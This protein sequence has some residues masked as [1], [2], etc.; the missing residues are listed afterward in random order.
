M[1]TKIMLGVDVGTTGAKAIAFDLGG[2]IV[3]MSYKEYGCSYPQ[4]GWAEQDADMLVET[5]FE[6]IKDV[7]SK[8]G[9]RSKNIC[10]L[11]FST[12]RNASIFLDKNGKALRMLTW[13]DSRSEH[14]VTRMRLLV[15]E[16][17]HYYTTGLP[18]SENWYLPKIVWMEKHEKELWDKTEKV[19]QLMEYLGKAYGADDYY[20]PEN[21]A[22]FTSCW[23]VGE[24]KW[25]E[26]YIDLFG[27]KEKARPKLMETSKPVG[28]ISPEIAR[29][30]GLPE[31]LLLPVAVGDTAAASLGAGIK[32]PGD[33]SVSMG[34]GGVTIAA[35]DKPVFHKDRAFML[36]HHIIRNRWQW[37]GLQ[38]ASAGVY[39]W[40]KDMLYAC[41]GAE[42]KSKG[43]NIYDILNE[44]IKNIP[45]GANG[46]MVLPYFAG[47]GTPNWSQSDR[48]CILGLSLSHG[49]EELM[50]ACMEGITF[51]QKQMVKELEKTGLEID[52]IRIMGGPTN[53]D[54]WNQMQADM[55]GKPVNTLKVTEAAALGA[56]IVGAVVNGIFASP[57]E[58][59]DML[60]KSAKCYEPGPN[61][62]AVYDELF[63][64]YNKA[65][66]GL[67][68]SGF[69]N[70]LAKFQKRR[71]R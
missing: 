13:Q 33:V 22:N 6:L 44:R 32:N 46:V 66:N 18:I 24:L 49:K 4:P 55:Y 41:E 16:S 38:M 61:T 69:T 28:R 62:S 47:S 15:P 31:G 59:A 9:E 52:S 2:N 56:A 14:E 67:C 40:F 11:G 30:L 5:T 3:E 27:M 71:N 57:E 39:R 64:I 42:A 19:V 29:K 43:L 68:S 34:T 1:N 50:R 10:S 21:D 25:K 65:Y 36:T 51:E 58:A 20:L 63:E 37:E 54:V 35:L 53:S 26:N 12:Q 17:D 7:V 48:G 60:V 8:L 45:P 23:D 70:D